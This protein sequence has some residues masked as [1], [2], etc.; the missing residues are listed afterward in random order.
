MAAGRP[1]FNTD[2]M[3]TS[4]ITTAADG[5]KFG[6]GGESVAYNKW[7][8]SG[9]QASAPAQPQPAQQQFDPPRAGQADQSLRSTQQAQGRAPAASASPRPPAPS[10]RTADR[11]TRPEGYV[12][13]STLWAQHA[14]TPEPE[15]APYNPNPPKAPRPNVIPKM[16]MGPSS[17]YLASPGYSTQA[18]WDQSK[19]KMGQASYSG[20]MTMNANMAN[21]GGESMRPPGFTFTAKGVDGKQY[22][23]PADAMARRDALITNLGQQQA[24]YSGSMGRN[25]GAPQ[26]NMKQAMGQGVR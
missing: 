16:Q 15:Q 5:T 19:G 12:P 20:A 1:G 22:A 2:N 6:N 10:M 17:S 25:L 7:R 8:A 9:G 24:R 11:Y 4:N 14:P 23:N 13:N 21:P 26:F 18:T 3:Y